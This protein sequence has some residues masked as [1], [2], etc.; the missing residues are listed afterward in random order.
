[1]TALVGVEVL[2]DPWW[3]EFNVTDSESCPTIACGQRGKR[4]WW[5]IL[6]TLLCFRHCLWALLATLVTERVEVFEC[7]FS[8]LGAVRDHDAVVGIGSSV[9]HGPFQAAQR[10]GIPV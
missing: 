2:L 9:C 5:A 10:Y 4:W 8:C 6:S 7:R 3:Q 1:M